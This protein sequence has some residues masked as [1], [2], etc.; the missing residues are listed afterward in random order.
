MNLVRKNGPFIES[1]L[2]TGKI[3]RNIFI[4]LIPII[5]YT[6]YLKGI[7]PFQE[8]GYILDLMWIFIT[9]AI[10]TSVSFITEILYQL[11]FTKRRK[12]EDL[13][14]DIKHNYSFMTGIMVGLLLPYG[15]N[16][17]V[18]VI[19][20]LSAT[21]IGKLFFGGFGN[22]TFNPP[23]IGLLIVILIFGGS[24][25]KLSQEYNYNGSCSETSIFDLCAEEPEEE[26]EF[27]EYS[28]ITY[29]DSE[30]SPADISPILCIIACCFLIITKS[31]KWRIP[32]FYLSTAFIISI[33][34]GLIHSIDFENSIECV[35]CGGLLFY[36]VFV[37]TDSVT[38]PVTKTGQILLGISLGVLTMFFRLV[39][40][41][42]YEATIFSI[43]IL[44]MF[45]RLYDMI[46]FNL[47]QKKSI[48][49]VPSVILLILTII[50]FVV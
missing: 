1:K 36:A 4:A 38:T 21:I 30:T 49:I 20:S 22:N 2:S 31:T 24:Y 39:T 46:G 26:P 25:S 35:I 19:A 41:Y 8:A 50:P 16:I 42:F 32:V 11:I 6:F 29:Y 40:P 14:F 17:L 12:K 9:L 7:I 37:A 28:N 10:T 45:T 47:K 15:V 48:I 13:V 5:L 18:M 44:N 33:V 34:F 27:D 23:L 3:M 43:L